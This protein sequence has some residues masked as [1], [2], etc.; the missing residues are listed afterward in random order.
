MAAATR[1]SADRAMRQID[2][3]VEPRRGPA[4]GFMAWRAVADHTVGGSIA[5]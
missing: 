2:E 3:I 5:L 1:R 4:E